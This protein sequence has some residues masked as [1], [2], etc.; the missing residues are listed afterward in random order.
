M[1]DFDMKTA[2]AINADIPTFAAFKKAL[3]KDKGMHEHARFSVARKLILEECL[4]LPLDQ[5][6]GQLKKLMVKSKD[7]GAVL[8]GGL[9]IKYA[10]HLFVLTQQ[11]AWLRLTGQTHEEAMAQSAEVQDGNT[12]RKVDIDPNTK[13]IRDGA[14]A[15]AGIRERGAMNRDAWMQ[16]GIGLTAG[17]IAS[18]GKKG[19]FQA[20]R[21]ANGYGDLSSADVRD[22]IWLATDEGRA[23]FGQADQKLTSPRWIR[24]VFRAEQRK[25]SPPK[26]T[27]SHAEKAI[28]EVKAIDNDADRVALVK[29]LLKLLDSMK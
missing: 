12:M 24:Q 10:R 13:V 25:D 8:D 3:A 21:E 28:D 9:N 5:W 29:E 27:K 4:P 2:K 7:A 17:K 23:F 16:V 19:G 15:L 18:K 6:N 22:A 20:W 26:P 1:T 11:N 14:K